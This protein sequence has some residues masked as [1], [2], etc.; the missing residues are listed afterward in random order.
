[1]SSP[2]GI[3]EK[4]LQ[5]GQASGPTR[6][7]FSGA[8]DVFDALGLMSG[9]AA[10]A[11]RLVFGAILGGGITYLVKPTVSFRQDG[12]PRPWVL[13]SPDAPDK[14]A[15]PWWMPAVAASLAFGF[16]V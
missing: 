8:E 3:V 14:T 9:S 16:L 10:P 13:S 2:Q 4:I 7:I 6:S 15:M 11:R 5:Q 12:M 1:M